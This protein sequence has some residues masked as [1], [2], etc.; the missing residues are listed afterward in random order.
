MLLTGHNLDS[1]DETEAARQQEKKRILVLDDEEGVRQ[2]VEMV[3]ER[4]Y[5]IFSAEKKK[6]VMD[7]LNNEYIDLI[8]TDIKLEYENGLDIMEEILKQHK[9][10][11]FIVISSSLDKKTV[12]RAER[13]GASGILDKPFS[14]RELLAF[15]GNALKNEAFFSL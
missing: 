5:I 11:K 6:D 3:L 2:A 7:I 15:V 10:V 1:K 12:N 13:M 14:V 4:D 9:K 8:I